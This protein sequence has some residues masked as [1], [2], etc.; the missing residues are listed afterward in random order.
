M[1]DKSDTQNVSTPEIP[2]I[3]YAVKESK[4]NAYLT[5]IPK[6]FPNKKRVYLQLPINVAIEP[7]ETETVD[8]KIEFSFPTTNKQTLLGRLNLS[9]DTFRAYRL[10]IKHNRSF[11][12]GGN[13]KAHITNNSNNT[14][15][16][17]VGS[18]PITISFLDKKGPKIF[19][20]PHS[21]V[22]RFNT[23]D[24]YA[25]NFKL[26]KL[27]LDGKNEV[28]ENPTVY[29]YIERINNISLKPKVLKNIKTF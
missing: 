23:L 2:V 20:E 21:P 4:M 12:Y 9:R 15:T 25:V 1:V 28:S 3:K 18:Y 29:Y 14:V 13:V 6:T 26:E 22:Q 10:E 27:S 11:Y 8:M 16:L 19:Y 7:G 5:P 24:A 17:K